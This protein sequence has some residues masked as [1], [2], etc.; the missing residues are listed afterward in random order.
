[1]VNASMNKDNISVL[2]GRLGQED[3]QTAV[4]FI[5]YLIAMRGKKEAAKSIDILSDI[6][7]SFKEDKGWDSEAAMLKDMAQFR[8]ERMGL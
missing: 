8:R 2:L 3:Y 1:M 7:A 6:Q 4:S 5:E